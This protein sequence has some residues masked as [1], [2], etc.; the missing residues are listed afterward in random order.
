MKKHNTICLVMIVKDE[1]RVIERCLSSV[2][3]IIDYWIISD[4]GSTDGTQD[5]IRNYFKKVG[6][7]GELHENPW[8]DFAYNRS[9]AWKKAK[10][11][12]EYLITLDADEVFKYEEDFKMPKLDKDA[13]YIM[14]KNGSIEYKRMQLAS[15]KFD[16]YYKD[17]LHEY[18]HNDEGI[19]TM[20]TINGM[21]NVPSPDGARSSD[22][23]KYKKDALTLEKALLDE[24]DN[25]RYVFYLAQSYRDCHDYDNA[26]KNYKKRA[27]LGGFEEETFYAMYEV[28]L[29]KMRRGDKFEE[30][31][32]D[33]LLAYNFRPSR[34]EPVHKIVRYCR[35]NN[36]SY[37][38]YNMFKY[39]LGKSMDT[40]DVLFV[41]RGIYDY[42]LLD[43][44]SMVAYWSGNYEDSVKILERIIRENKFPENEKIRFLNHLKF[45]K[46]ELEKK[47]RFPPGKLLSLQ[48]KS[49]DWKKIDRN[50]LEQVFTA[51]IDANEWGYDGQKY[52]ISTGY[53]NT[54]EVTESYRELLKKHIEINKIKSV[55]DI[56]CGIWEYD[57]DE[58]KDCMYIGIDCVKN[59]IY[60]NKK[61]YANKKRLFIYADILDEKNNIPS[62]I[63][64][65]I[66]KDVLQHLSEDN[67]I[68][69]LNK[70]KSKVKYIILVQDHDQPNHDIP[71]GGYRPLSIK[72]SPLK[73]FEPKLLTYYSTKEVSLLGK[74]MEN[75][76]IGEEYKQEDK[77]EDKQEVNK[78][79]I[80]KNI[81]K[82]IEMK[83]V[84]KESEDKEE[85]KVIKKKENNGKVLL[86]I[87]ARNKAHVLPKYLDCISNLEYDKKLVNIYINTNNNSDDT[88]KILEKWIKL[89]E[90]K[91]A[92]IEF[93]RGDI[94]ELNTTGTNPHTWT[95][96]RFK[97]LGN[98]RNK[99][100]QKCLEKKCDYYFVVDCDNF[101]EPYTLKELIEED[102]PIIAP[103]LRAIPE[104]NDSYSNYFCDVTPN[105][106]Y[107][108]HK[109]YVKILSGE[110]IGSFNVPVVH[111]SYLIQSQYIEKLSYID[112]TQHHG[113]V[114]FSRSA[115]KNNVDQYICNKREYGK[116][117]HFFDEHLKLDEE[118]KRLE[119]YELKNKY[120]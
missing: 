64:L 96:V 59:V 116:C 74:D 27:K 19:K 92:G 82:N 87:L 3:D 78:E 101:I 95:N 71:N 97:V 110:M 13:Y 9:L 75:F 40:H 109:D 76:V 67:V 10:G 81:E 14:T 108:N 65:C 83:V 105:G 39:L 32:G 18:L 26:I 69:L 113:F 89:N 56:G 43:E 60:F 23:N 66:I 15:D 102:K 104:N 68:K 72:R 53:G 98:I 46:E 48:K 106:Y 1:S 31:V 11:K 57:H 45:S 51:I 85:I 8:R 58:F 50:N 70:V 7:E 16:W 118:I 17:V 119:R 73:D 115:R 30:F 107:K 114:I 49:I 4:T 47:N 111:C 84:K 79:K 34:L 38:G 21:Y 90:D 120:I 41:E 35:L 54:E 55:I 86:S 62:N 2:K 61:N 44:L 5:I 12:A 99:S 94:E 37:L 100:M 80:E 88:E 91:Y 63:D 29:C 112:K 25:G 77:Q 42:K 20:G 33:L 6:I 52:G 22:R 103:M 24:P 117:V 93:E 28:G 36:L